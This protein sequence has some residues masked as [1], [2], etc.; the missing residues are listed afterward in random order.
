MG[1]PLHWVYFW[2][3]TIPTIFRAT[4]GPTETHHEGYK[5][6]V[7]EWMLSVLLFVWSLWQPRPD[8]VWYEKI[9]ADIRRL[10]QKKQRRADRDKQSIAV[11]MYCNLLMTRILLWTLERLNCITFYWPRSSVQALYKP[12]WILNGCRNNLGLGFPSVASPW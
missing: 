11:L 10:I 5:V 1:G 3:W 8:D 9:E 12:S 6:I 4:N 7:L 2:G